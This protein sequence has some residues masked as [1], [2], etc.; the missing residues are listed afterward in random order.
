MKILQHNEISKRSEPVTDIEKQVKPFIEE[1]ARLCRTP[2][3][4]RHGIAIAHCQVEKDNPLRFYVFANGDCVVN[5]LIISVN[6]K[7]WMMHPE[8]CLSFKNRPMIAVPRYRII[9]ARYTLVNNNGVH[10]VNKKLHDMTAFVMQ[11]ETDHFDLKYIYDE[12]KI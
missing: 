4:G 11:H 9:K 3:N 5:P 7:T 10:V 8:G 12:D 6:E 1:M 2:I